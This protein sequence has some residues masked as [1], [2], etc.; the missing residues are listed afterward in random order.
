MV[1]AIA[2]IIGAIIGISGGIIGSKLI[3][4]NILKNKLR[5]VLK[6]SIRELIK[7]EEAMDE[8]SLEITVSKLTRLVDKLTYY[9]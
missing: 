3:I 2:G 1:A 6:N 8:D 9:E 7:I 4:R 5:A